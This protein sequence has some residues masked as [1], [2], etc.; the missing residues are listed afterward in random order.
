M[1]VFSSYADL[2]KF[3]PKKNIVTINYGK[4]LRRSGNSIYS[5][6]DVSQCGTFIIDHP[7]SC[8]I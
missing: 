5:Y 8:K 6:K 4:K 3:Y 1:Y 7:I 2:Q